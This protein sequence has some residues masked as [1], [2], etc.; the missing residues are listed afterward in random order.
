MKHNKAVTALSALAQDTR[1]SIFLLL[2]DA[3]EDGIAAG[4]L[5]AQLEIPPTTMSFHLS[6]LKA[7]NL[8]SSSKE[9]RSIIYCAN[10]KRAKKL[11]S[12]I[13]GKE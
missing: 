5:S 4:V 9:G 1:L 10:R 8:V 3:G 11:A 12:Y 7:A 6:Q 2:L 13:M